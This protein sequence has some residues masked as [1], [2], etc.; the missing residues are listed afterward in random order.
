MQARADVQKVEP[1][2]YRAM[3]ALESY[4]RNSTRL[5]PSLPELVVPTVLTCTARM[6]E[7]QAKPNSVCTR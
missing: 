4:V 6:R 2:A 1:G 5:E 3:A 7:R